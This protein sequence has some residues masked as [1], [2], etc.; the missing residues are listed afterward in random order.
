MKSLI[1]EKKLL[2]R[3]EITW[4][5]YENTDMILVIPRH[6]YHKGKMCKKCRVEV[7]FMSSPA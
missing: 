3:A 1:N 6:S 5:E 7:I 4:S 2:M